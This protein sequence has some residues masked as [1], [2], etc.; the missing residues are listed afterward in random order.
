L[1]Q[2]LRNLRYYF[3]RTILLLFR[4]VFRLLFCLVPFWVF[5]FRLQ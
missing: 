2:Q 1:L 4:G 5:I 3:L